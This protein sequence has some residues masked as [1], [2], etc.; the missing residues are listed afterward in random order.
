MLHFDD[1]MTRDFIASH[2]LDAISGQLGA[3]CFELDQRTCPGSE[4]TGW[5]DLP[6]R[7]NKEELTRVRKCAERLREEVDYLVVIGIGGSYLG[8]RAVIEAL[9]HH[10]DAQLP[11]D[12]RSGP[13]IIFAGHQLSSDYLY[14]LKELLRGRR[15]AFNVISKSGTTTEPA[16]AFRVLREA[17]FRDVSEDVFRKR[18]IITTDRQRGALRRLAEERDLETFV[19]PDDVGGR[20]SVLTPVGLLPVAVAGIDIDE[21]LDGAASSRD[22]EVQETELLKKP[23]AR[24]AAVR[25]LLARKGYTTEILG[26]YEP[27]MRM[28]TEWWK[29]LF[30]ESACK[31]GRGVIPLGVDFTT[32]LHSLGQMIQEGP[33]TFFETIINFRNVHHEVLI[34]DDGTNLDQL[35]Y[36]AGTPM[37]EVNDKAMLG[38]AL[39]HVAGGVPNMSVTC[40]KRSAFAMGELIY[41]FERACALSCLMDAVNPFNQPGVEAYKSNMFALLGKPGHEKRRAE[42]E[43]L[44]AER[45]RR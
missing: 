37:S 33:R 35:Q 4:Y 24:Y 45:Q 29:Q 19:I 27:S 23:A 26:A 42:L 22:Q 7:E 20:F 30:G 11:N 8:A 36:L 21:L 12:R 39:A 32:D 9:S 25:T 34:P 2:E 31:D 28:F 10:F 3:A 1:Q 15:V 38:T 16:V 13:K 14:D 6:D 17:L 5:L 41:F 40:E 18:V 43:S 44:L